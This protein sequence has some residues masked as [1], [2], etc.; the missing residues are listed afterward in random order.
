MSIA[1]ILAD[2]CSDIYISSVEL[3]ILTH[4]LRFHHK[5]YPING[6]SMIKIN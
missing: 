4:C 6:R 2:F 5:L 1:K 3:I